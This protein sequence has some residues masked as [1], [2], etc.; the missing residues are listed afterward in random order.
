VTHALPPASPVSIAVPR[1]RLSWFSQP[2][3]N[4][5]PE[6][7][8]GF[9]VTKVLTTGMGETT[10]DFLVKTVDP[11][12]AVAVAVL[13]LGVVLALQLSVRR[14][15]PALYWAAV[16]MV[17]IA[18]TMV[19][20]VAHV[21]AGISYLVSS[22]AFSVALAVVFL[23]WYATQRTLSIHSITTRIRE[24]FYWAAI[25]VTFALGT[26]TG[27]LTAA[28]LGW[29][30]FASGVLFAVVIAVPILAYRRQW[31]GAT[32]AFWFAYIVTRPLGASFSDWFAVSPARGGLDLGTGPVSVVLFLAIAA[33]VVYLARADR[34]RPAIARVRPS[35]T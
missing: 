17:S 29:G 32:V 6:A 15:V 16:V 19:A 9:W 14:Y 18:G 2:M 10:S 28:T 33:C 23:A 8:V 11:V 4:K 30:Y 1:R 21:V 7:T 12:Y 27:D 22:V 25:V 31:L 24:L 34:A 35:S 20:D 3:L 5:V 13:V 26:A